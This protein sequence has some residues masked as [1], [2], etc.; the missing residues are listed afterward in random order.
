MAEMTWKRID[1]VPDEDWEQAWAY[2]SKNDNKTRL[3]KG[4]DHAKQFA[5]NGY[6]KGPLELEDPPP[7]PPAIYRFEADY[8][9]KRVSGIY[10]PG[11]ES[12]NLDYL[13]T[14]HAHPPNL[15]HREW[16]DREDLTS[17]HW[18]NQPPEVT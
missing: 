15:V 10:N 16:C 9:G 7:D 1:E 3:A 2:K 17:I 13:V 6:V 12:L 14:W 8:K 4:R 11:H 5:K 18:K